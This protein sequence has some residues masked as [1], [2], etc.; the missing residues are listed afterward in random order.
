[1][2][3]ALLASVAVSAQSLKDEADLLLR[4]E[5]RQQQIAGMAVA[6]VR[7]AGTVYQGTLGYADLQRAQEVSVGTTFA[8]GT[9]GQMFLNVS[10]LMLAETGRIN[11]ESEV[12]ARIPGVR[13]RQAMAQ[14]SGLANFL[15]AK[16][17]KPSPST[18]F[19]Q[20]VSAIRSVSRPPKLEGYS[21]TNGLLVTRAVETATG[22]PAA[23]W[24]RQS[25]FAPNGMTNTSSA[26]AGASAVGYRGDGTSLVRDPAVF[27]PIAPLYGAQFV[28]N[29]TDMI[30][31]SKVFTSRVGLKRSTWDMALIPP[32]GNEFA[33]AMQAGTFDGETKWIGREGGLDGFSSAFVHLPNT[34]TSIIILTNSGGVDTLSIAQGLAF[35]LQ[36]NDAA[37]DGG[38]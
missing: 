7:P 25:V 16:D 31:W 21:D 26:P 15:D 28:T 1:M 14:A 29:L 24:V 35:I 18:S 30:R 9:T 33:L 10:A 20:A 32:R 4:E 8:L 27:T 12:D 3:V 34:Q 37:P 11:L 22:Q 23:L 2:S 6:I 17:L 38:L 13:L 36:S 19:E 5:M